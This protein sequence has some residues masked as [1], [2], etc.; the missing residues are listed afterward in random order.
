[1]IALAAC[2][3]RD[4]PHCEEHGIYMDV[5]TASHRLHLCEDHEATRSFDVRLGWGGVGKTTEGDQRT[6]LGEYPLGAARA[7]M[8]YGTFVPIG[9]PTAEQKAKGF[10]GSAVGVHGPD[11]KYAWL[12]AFTNTLDTTDG[13]VG[14]AT[15][16]E[17]SEISAWLRANPA[18]GI[19]LR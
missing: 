4:P 6:P 5:D 9:Y 10:T 2:A 15:D 1:V 12:G 8:K 18:R 14:L 16:E 3:T 7:S 11:R 19:T 17:M 13:C